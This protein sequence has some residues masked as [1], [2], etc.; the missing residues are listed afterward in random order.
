MCSWYT[1]TLYFYPNFFEHLHI[2]ALLRERSGRCSRVP[3]LDELSDTSTADFLHEVIHL[4]SAAYW[5]DF[6]S[7]VQCPNFEYY[8]TQYRMWCIIDVPVDFPLELF[9]YDRQ[10]HDWMAYGPEACE[11]LAFAPDGAEA[12]LYNADSWTMFAMEAVRLYLTQAWEER[13]MRSGVAPMKRI[14][15]DDY[16]MS[17]SDDGLAT[18]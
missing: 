6:S 10:R 8:C 2:E 5:D 9:L 17:V 1:R 15:D 4:V 14:G 3:T 16:T 7:S 11:E 18:P 13:W 12:S